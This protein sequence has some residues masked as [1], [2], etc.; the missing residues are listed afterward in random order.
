[1]YELV[2]SSSAKSDKA[3]LG[4]VDNGVLKLYVKLYDMVVS[5]S[6]WSTAFQTAYK[7]HKTGNDS[8]TIIFMN[9]VF[10][11]YTLEYLTLILRVYADDISQ[12]KFEYV[13][14]RISNGFPSFV[15][16][17]ADNV[18]PILINCENTKNPK[19]YVDNAIKIEKN[20]KSTESDSGAG[21]K[22]DCSDKSLE[23]LNNLYS[24][25]DALIAAILFGAVS[26]LSV[27][28]IIHTIRYIIY[29]MSCLV[30]DITKSLQ[31]QS[32]TLLVSIESLE[33]KLSTL[34]PDSKE[35]KDLVKVIESQKYYTKLLIDATNKLSDSEMENIDDIR[36]KE[37]DDDETINDD[38]G[39]SEDGDGGLDI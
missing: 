33:R 2:T 5:N 38:S 23:D 19:G 9:Y 1:M 31:D 27:I 7:F 30:V 13:N 21:Y 28:T 18:I 20:K 39:G 10:M 15:K 12:Y 34:K 22:V 4:K 26:I 6:K 24:Q 37:Y 17:A 16:A 3:K 11:V 32:Y 29:S 36:K 25:E 14:E 8:S 35:Y